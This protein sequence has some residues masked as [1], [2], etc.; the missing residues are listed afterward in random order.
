[1]KAQD[2]LQVLQKVQVDSTRK[3]AIMEVL[4]PTLPG[5][6]FWAPPCGHGGLQS[7]I[8]DWG[9]VQRSGGGTPGSGPLLCQ[10]WPAQLTRAPA[11]Q[12]VRSHGS[13]LLSADEF[14]K[15]FNEFDRRVTKEVTGAGASPAQGHPGR[16]GVC[17]VCGW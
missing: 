7:P 3:Q 6:C 12:R 1:M 16:V 14:Q 8:W 17:S 10:A 13:G 15:L 11:L 5:L 4:S 2:L 9:S